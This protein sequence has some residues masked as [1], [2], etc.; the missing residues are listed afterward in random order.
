MA[1]GEETAQNSGSGGH[2]SRAI[3]GSFYCH[4]AIFLT[5][6]GANP[7][8]ARLQVLDSHDLGHATFVVSRNLDHKTANRAFSICYGTPGSCENLLD[9]KKT[10]LDR[11]K[12]RRERGHRRWAPSAV[13]AGEETAQNSGSGGPAVARSR[14]VFIAIQAIFLTNQGANPAVARL[15][16][17]DSHDLGHATSAV[18]NS[19][20]YVCLISAVIGPPVIVSLG[21]PVAWPRSRGSSAAADDG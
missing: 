3:Q 10:T 1:A 14:V 16:V 11:N 13:A 21:L 9:G 2:G 7:A 19:G 5:N 12:N 20:P 6:Q 8:V 18:S 15:Q 17:L 4:Q